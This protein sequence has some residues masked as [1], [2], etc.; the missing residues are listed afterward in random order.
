MKEIRVPR[1]CFHCKTM[2]A[3]GRWAR[4]WDRYL[5]AFLHHWV[6]AACPD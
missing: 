3:N 4:I 1:S 2:T 6:C 5:E